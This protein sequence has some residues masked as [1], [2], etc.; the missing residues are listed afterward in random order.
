MGVCGAGALTVGG[1]G[2]LVE[3][4][5][6]DIGRHEIRVSKNG[7]R[8]PLKILHL[9]D[10]H[11]GM[12]V[13]LKFIEHAIQL[14]LQWQPDLICLTGDYITWKYSDW[15]RYSKVL[16]QLSKAAPTFATL[17]NHDG[18]HWAGNS[19]GYKSA[20]P[21]RQLLARS[22][23]LLLEND[24][25]QI[26]LHDWKLNV[27]GMNDL[28]SRQFNPGKAFSKTRG[29]EEFTTTVL[30]HNPDTKDFF[31]VQKW[32]LLLAGH[33]HG[34]QVDLPIIGTPFAPVRDKRFIKG[35]HRWN[36]HWIHITK[37]IGN[38][39]GIRIN[40]RPEVSFLTLL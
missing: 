39:H 35:L 38:V 13:S 30:S 7:E 10:L 6:I 34:G 19:R 26:E 25:R 5:W 4:K 27:V 37:G 21:V 28:W 15:D 32:D 2:N 22:N 16:S 17:G 12:M 11:A 1:Y 33:T 3:S 8:H 20:E 14:G 36:D 29:G 31:P 23:I 24:A 18:G 40:C 9:S